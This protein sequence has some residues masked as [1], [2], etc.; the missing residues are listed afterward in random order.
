M[1][2]PNEQVLRWAERTLGGGARVVAWEALKLQDTQ[3]TWLLRVEQGHASTS[4]VLKTSPLGWDA[5]VAVEKAV[6]P[7]LEELGVPAPRLLGVDLTGHAGVLA[8]L[9]T[10]VPGSSGRPA[11]APLQRL[12]GLGAAAARLHAIPLHPRS[13]LPHR[14]RPVAYDPYVAERREGKAPTSSLLDEADHVVSNVVVPPADTVLVHGDYHLANTMWSD[15][16]FVGYIDWD[17][18]GVGQ[19]GI[20]LGWARFD[21]AL[22]YSQQAADEILRGWME[23]TGYEPA[24]VAYWD[25]I[26]A[27]QSPADLGELSPQRDAF[28]LSALQRLERC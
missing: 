14:D 13:D 18:A 3:K 11:N 7:L 2:D 23:E 22:F 16:T 28:L 27:L 8:V 26:A 4:L 5:G 21:A 15:D 19:P 1:S 12:R 25:A 6:L 10:V 24:G 9:S 17:T 20:D